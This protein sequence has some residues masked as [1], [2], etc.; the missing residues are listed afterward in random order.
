VNENIWAFT[1]DNKILVLSTDGKEVD[2][3]SLSPPSSKSPSYSSKF[4][5]TCVGDIF[6]WVANAEFIYVLHAKSVR[7]ISIL[8]NESYVTAMVHL[9]DKTVWVADANGWISIWHI[10]L[11]KC[12]K[13]K[14]HDT[15]CVL[16]MALL[17]E[18]VWMGVGKDVSVCDTQ[19][20]TSAEYEKAHGD[21]IQ[22]LVALPKQQ[23]VWTCARDGSLCMWKL[24]GEGE[25]I[26]LK[27]IKKVTSSSYKFLC[28]L[29]DGERVCS[30]SSDG[31]LIV[32]DIKTQQCMGIFTP[33]K[34]K[35][36]D[37]QCVLDAGENSFWCGLYKMSL[38]KLNM[39]LC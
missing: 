16:S 28:L 20:R 12:A 30:R 9:H 36:S 5:V 22:D 3:K 27:Q 4:V 38:F 7:L 32:W 1:S 13:F 31:D 19:G 17:G 39:R 23:Q 24:E 11:Q 35:Q 18:Y 8:N 10:S 29:Q 15:Q 37:I 33:E 25:R 2:K 6:I 14:V 21:R 34:M 26:T